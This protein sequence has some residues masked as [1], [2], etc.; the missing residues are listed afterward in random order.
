MLFFFSFFFFSLPLFDCQKLH[1]QLVAV[2]V[3]L[4]DE[5]KIKRQSKA[6]SHV[7]LFPLCVS[8]RANRVISLSFVSRTFQEQL[9][10]FLLF[11]FL[12]LP[13]YVLLL[14]PHSPSSSFSFSLFLSFFLF[15]VSCFVNVC[16]V[17][18]SGGS[19]KAS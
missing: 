4:D 14:A 9:I 18:Q 6:K 17:H 8:I 12:P 16:S 5:N 15:P 11:L 19:S 13:F 1:S 2:F 7:L 3:L 10:P